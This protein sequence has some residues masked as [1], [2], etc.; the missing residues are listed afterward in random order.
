MEKIV[1][2]NIGF[3]DIET[4]RVYSEMQ[5]QL[6]LLQNNREVFGNCS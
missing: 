1:E 4:T 6:V 2:Y 5:Y 3:Y